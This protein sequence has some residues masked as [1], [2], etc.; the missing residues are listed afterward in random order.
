MQETQGMQS[1]CLIDGHDGGCNNGSNSIFTI[2]EDEVEESREE[3]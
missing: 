3:Q 2:I 1:Q